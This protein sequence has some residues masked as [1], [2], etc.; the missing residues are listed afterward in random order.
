MAHRPE[1]SADDDPTYHLL[2]SSDGGATF[3]PEV[4]PPGQAYYSDWGYAAGKLFAVGS[5]D[6]IDIIP[7][8]TPTTST[9]LR[10]L[11]DFGISQDRRTLAVNAI[12]DA[13]IVSQLDSGSVVIDRL[14]AG[15][16]ALDP[17]RMLGAGTS[18]GVVAA[19]T[20]SAVIVYSDVQGQVH[21]A[22]QSY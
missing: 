12:G 1:W 10:L 15:A 2:S 16:T 20:S 9:R 11:P 14:A 6:E 7:T 13:F 21:A 18:P 22:V 4:T 3:A 17:Q 8:A 5:N 19:S